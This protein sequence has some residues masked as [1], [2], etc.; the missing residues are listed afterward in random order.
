MISFLWYENLQKVTKK[1][2]NLLKVLPKT[3]LFRNIALIFSLE[4]VAHN[5]PKPFFSQSSPAHSPELIFH[6]INMSEDASVS[7]SVLS[8]SAFLMEFWSE[9]MKTSN[10]PVKFLPPLWSEFCRCEQIWKAYEFIICNNYWD[11]SYTNCE[12]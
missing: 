8:S 11:K 12:S 7:L 5:Q 1:S 10:G 6:I 9:C 4:K 2:Q 3:V